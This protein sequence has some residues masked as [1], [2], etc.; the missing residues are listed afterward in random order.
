LLPTLLPAFGAFV[1]PYE[2]SSAFTASSSAGRP[3][4]GTISIAM[5]RELIRGAGALKE[6]RRLE[7]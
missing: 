6:R 1:I 4:S 5:V 2:S 7:W 3:I